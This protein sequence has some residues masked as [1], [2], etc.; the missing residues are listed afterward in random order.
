MTHSS[1][2]SRFANRASSVFWTP[3]SKATATIRGT[4]G[5][6]VPIPESLGVELSPVPE[7]DA[8]EATVTLSDVPADFRGTIRCE[9]HFES[10][11][12]GRPS[13][14]VPITGVVL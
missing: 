10:G 13:L 6:E 3:L 7:E 9:L 1:T 12:E 8:M 4:L 11:Y 14:S 2:T 5:L